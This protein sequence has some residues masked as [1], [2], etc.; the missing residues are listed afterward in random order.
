MSKFI[1]EVMELLV[2][3]YPK[4]MSLKGV[5]YHIIRHDGLIIRKDKPLSEE[6][7]VALPVSNSHIKE[8]YIEVFTEA[9]NKFIFRYKDVFKSNP[10]VDLELLE[11]NIS[12]SRL[13]WIDKERYDNINNVISELADELSNKYSMEIFLDNI[14]FSNG[15]IS[16]MINIITNN[17][18]FTSP[19]VN[20]FINNFDENVNHSSIK[21]TINQRIS[22]YITLINKYFE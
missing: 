13:Y 14:K 1:N 10:V 4:E 15:N 19:V 16:F 7:E 6:I 20:I 3:H 17:T 5:S 2:A 11:K 18:K 12:A 8:S 9:Y 21:S 22:N